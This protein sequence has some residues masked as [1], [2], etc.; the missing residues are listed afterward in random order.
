MKHPEPRRHQQHPRGVPGAYQGCTRARGV[1]GA[2]QCQGYAAL[3]HGRG[4]GGAALEERPPQA[5]V[6][7]H[8][9]K[10][11]AAGASSTPPSAS[12]PPCAWASLSSVP[13][14]ADTTLP[15]AGPCVSGAPPHQTP[16]APQS[17]SGVLLR[18]G[19]L[20]R[21]F[22]AHPPLLPLLLLG[23]LAP[24]PAKGP[25]AALSSQRGLSSPSSQRGLSSLSSQSGPWLQPGLSCAWSE[26]PRAA[27]RVSSAMA[28]VCVPIFWRFV[29]DARLP[30][31]AGGPGE[32]LQGLV[33]RRVGA[34]S[35]P[36]LLGFLLRL[37]LGPSSFLKGPSASPGLCSFA[38]PPVTAMAYGDTVLGGGARLWGA[39]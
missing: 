7:A 9:V 35:L 5:G 6:E 25:L 23:P 33:P 28:F 15:C 17:S 36:P 12:L 13:S 39:Q 21:V 8:G 3:L 18:G 10:G 34:V 26:G 4:V 38:L 14:R 19:D 11:R 31:A 2:Y 1:P 37:R 22:H 32:A 20:L 24:F 30:A 16:A 27:P 29:G